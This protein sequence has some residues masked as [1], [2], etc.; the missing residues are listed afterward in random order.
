MVTCVFTVAVMA[1]CIWTN[2]HV[3]NP[4]NLV[5]FFE[6]LIK[7][8]SKMDH[9][10]LNCCPWCLLL[11]PSLRALSVAMEE[12][13][14]VLPIPPCVFSVLPGSLLREGQSST[15]A[16][17][18]GLPLGMSVVCERIGAWKTPK[19]AL[20]ARHS[21]PVWLPLALKLC[22]LVESFLQLMLSTTA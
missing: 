1:Q 18:N 7:G 21:C 16:L 5:F 19:E 14:D 10:C 9:G 6:Y 15:E 8:C 3:S 4:W 12:K 22:S 13:T 20:W 2:Y 11:L 17:G